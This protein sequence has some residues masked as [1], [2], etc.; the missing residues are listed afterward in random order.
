MIRVIPVVGLFLFLSFAANAWEASPPEGGYV[1]DTT[2]F[3]QSNV[4]GVLAEYNCPS[5]KTAIFTVDTVPSGPTV[6]NAVGY[7]HID[8][9]AVVDYSRKLYVGDDEVSCTAQPVNG[10]R[11]PQVA[12]DC[13]KGGRIQIFVQDFGEALLPGFIHTE[14]GGVVIIK[15]V[16]WKNNSS[17][18]IFPIT[19][20]TIT[21]ANVFLEHP[22]F[23]SSQNVPG[24]TAFETGTGSVGGIA[25]VQRKAG[26]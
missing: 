10:H 7:S 26:L 23:A 19:V 9:L 4:S 21:R 8:P 24:V 25:Y 16:A 14:H 17:D 6:N 2:F 15:A 13:G 5:Y 1:P 18:V 3:A 12:V 11:C 22:S 20:T